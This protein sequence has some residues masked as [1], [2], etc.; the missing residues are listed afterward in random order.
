G[1]AN[2]QQI[3]GG[4]VQQR[5]EIRQVRS[6]IQPARHEGGGGTKRTFSPDVNATLFGITRRELQRRKDERDEETNGGDDPNDERAWPGCG[7]RR[8]PTQTERGNDVEKEEVAESERPTQRA[9]NVRDGG[10]R[11]WRP[12]HA[13]DSGRQRP[14]VSTNRVS[15]GTGSGSGSDGSPG[16]TM[17][18]MPSGSVVT[19]GSRR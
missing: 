9:A 13:A 16:K 10:L 8:N 3:A 7:C 6:P 4:K 17:R 18:R 5:R 15:K 19:R 12:A 14:S 2:E 1:A 11:R